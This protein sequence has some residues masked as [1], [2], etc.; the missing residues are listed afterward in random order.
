MKNDS[1]SIMWQVINCKHVKMEDKS[2][3][4]FSDPKLLWLCANFDCTFVS[5]NCHVRFGALILA[6]VLC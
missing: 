5:V 4:E 1:K 6:V 2:W 3:I